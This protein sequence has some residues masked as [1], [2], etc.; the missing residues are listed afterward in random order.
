[1]K[2]AS[3]WPAALLALAIT[4]GAVARQPAPDLRTIA[5]KS[6]YHATARHE[7]VV[8]LL[9]TLGASDPRAARLTLGH[10]FEGREIPLLV[11]SDPPVRTPEQAHALADKDGRAIILLFGDIHAGEVCGKE[12]LPVLA[13]ELL[14]SPDKST[15][16]RSIV[17]FAPIYNCD[18]NDRF[19]PVAE[20]RP[21]QDGPADGCGVRHNA[22]D[23]D[24]NRDFVKLEAPETRAL[25]GFM[26]AWD[27]HII[28]D[29]H[30]TNGSY[31]RYL[32]TYA[33]AKVPAG[34]PGVVSFTRDRFIPEVAASY[35]RATGLPM[36]WYGS[37]E[38][39]FTDA[40]RGHSRWETFPAQPRYGTNYIG[41]RGRLSMLSEAYS[42]SP[43]KERI[44]GTL[45]F[46]RA[47]VQFGAAHGAEVR[48]LAAHADEVNAGHAPGL[49]SIAIRTKAEPFPG[50]LTLLGFEEEVK[51][52]RVHST[53]K[54]AE[55]PV[56][57]WDNWVPEVTIRRPAAYVFLDRAENVVE[58]LRL[59]GI[60][61]ERLRAELASKANVYR[62]DAARP[63]TR[64]F[65]GHTIADVDATQRTEDLRLS[66]GT[67]VV[68]TNQKLGN[69]AC[70]LLEPRSEDGLAA[71]NFFDRWLQ[72]GGDFPIA[73]LESL[74]PGA[75]EPLPE[76]EDTP[77]SP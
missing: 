67:L 28:V 55:Y 5:E 50:K 53:G 40:P 27:P 1:M 49:E 44:M 34:D 59:H 70:Y 26:N 65:Q 24:L 16:R 51:D 18:G 17:C 8:R 76:P 29:T 33:G 45:E 41:L 58:N 35:T 39:A 63:A 56:E 69:L 38:G 61:V 52:G 62:I 12:A 9:D 64:P 13:R 11:L 75:T 46:C 30:T 54:P 47:I 72:P 4:G 3:N 21:G 14:A 57:L 20:H 77:A 10:S 74:D 48:S 60:H 42:Y 43:Y 37:F 71:W 31:H 23:L 25:V 15:L 66:P 68:R 2:L 7:D 6:D 36:F 19:G 73:R 22:Q 32:I